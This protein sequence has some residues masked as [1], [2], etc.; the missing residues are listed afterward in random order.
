MSLSL[1]DDGHFEERPKHLIDS[2]PEFAEVS[3]DDDD[4]AASVEQSFLERQT[5][6][7]EIT[8]TAA[9]HSAA[10]EARRL[11]MESEALDLKRAQASGPGA[12][13]TDD[14]DS[15]DYKCLRMILSNC[16]GE[17]SAQPPAALAEE[18]SASSAV[19]TTGWLATVARRVKCPLERA[20]KFRL[21]FTAAGSVLPQVL[22][23]TQK[24]AMGEMA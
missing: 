5:K 3:D 11:R 8:A 6:V 18:P 4:A 9:V 10:V 19:A 24:T 1:G 17:V 7:A 14:Y 23:S 15:H 12:V 16:A 20:E 21:R 2:E 22:S 13:A